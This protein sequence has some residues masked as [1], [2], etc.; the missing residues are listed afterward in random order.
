MLYRCLADTN[1][2]AICLVLLI[3]VFCR[4]LAFFGRAPVCS[5]VDYGPISETNAAA[6]DGKEG[7]GYQAS[8]Q[9]S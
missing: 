3:L 1:I 8:A 6:D 4:A 9:P 2:L 5:G 7:D